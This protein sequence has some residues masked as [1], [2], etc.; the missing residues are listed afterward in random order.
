V[1]WHN[2]NVEWWY[3]QNLFLYVNRRLVDT[4]AKYRDA[5]QFS[6]E[7]GMMLVHEN[8]LYELMSVRGYLKYLRHRSVRQLRQ[9]RTA[10]DPRRWAIAN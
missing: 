10:A 4:E 3:R 1:L 7:S 2:R 5:Y 8:L 6:A 9:L